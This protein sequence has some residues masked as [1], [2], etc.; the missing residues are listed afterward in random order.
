MWIGIICI[1][2][3]INIICVITLILYKRQIR[4]ICRQMRFVIEKNSNLEVT[5]DINSREINELIHDINELIATYRNKKVQIEKKSED[6]KETITN[7]SHDIRTP[8]TSLNGYFEFLKEVEDEEKQQKYTEIIQDRINCLK[9]MLEQLFTYVKLQNDEYEFEMERLNITAELSN[10]IVSFYEEI[11]SRKFEPQISI[12]DSP[13]YLNLNKLAFYRIFENIIKNAIEHG[14]DRLIIEMR[15]KNMTVEGET[16]EMKN[17]EC[18]IVEIVISNTIRNAAE[19][20]HH[21]DINKTLS[22]EID[23]NKIFSRFYKADKSRSQNSTGL[24]L[25]IAHDMVCKMGGEI[26]AEV[27]NG[28]FSVKVRWRC[29]V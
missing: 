24:G 9:D 20:T 8:L 15:I 26:K 13:V 28:M 3:F 23:V 29:G 6:L 1:L 12:V 16:D 2:S 14:T 25:A 10:I 11:K 22:D 19:D 17:G 18:R 7:I 21:S 4:S 27:E 5:R